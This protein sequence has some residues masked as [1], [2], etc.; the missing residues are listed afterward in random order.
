MKSVSCIFILFFC[1][2]VHCALLQDIRFSCA[3][4]VCTL[5][6]P[7]SSKESLPNYFQ[8]FD[9]SK[10][11]LRVAFSKTNISMENGTYIVDESSAWI[12][13][14]E[15]SVDKPKDLL[16]LD[17]KCGN[18]ITTDKN[19]VE[20]RNKTD[21]AINF[22]NPGDKK[23]NSWALSKIGATRAKGSDFKEKFSITPPGVSSVLVQKNS[24]WEELLIVLNFE[25]H[26]EATPVITDS[27]VE[28]SIEDGPSY[29]GVFQTAKSSFA[30]GL[31]W[32][33]GKLVVYLY[34]GK[35]PAVM[36]MKNRML[37]QNET[38]P[39]KLENWQAFA[40]SLKSSNYF[41]PSYEPLAQGAADFARRLEKKQ[42]T[43]SSLAQAIQVKRSD[44]SYIVVEEIASLF[45]NPSEGKPLEALVFGDR[46]KVLEKRPPFY[47]VRYQNK[48]GYVY[49]RDILQEAELTTSQREELRRRQKESPGGVDSIAAK[50]GWK[51]SDKIIYSS[52]GFR[53]PFI[54]VRG[55]GSDGINIDNLILAGVVY[56]NEMPMALFSDNK[57]RGQSYTLHEGDSVKNGK[58]IKISK[59]SVL[60]L[61]QE[62]GVSR[63]YTMSLPDKFGGNK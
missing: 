58:V 46:L 51:D 18:A 57:T 63:R 42:G 48:E 53:D 36:I 30:K 62:Y 27:T 59:T 24:E 60:F 23:S 15:I 19:L 9:P 11:V 35:K 32:T 45:P 56:E 25:L 43:E 17:F 12:R 29:S 20:L 61:L 4:N 40:T 39:G 3:S 52:Y 2:G 13:S 10:S 44:A 47:K 8:K 21:F 6:F 50:F 26:K 1:I 49:Q 5:E 33:N 55:L 7:F 28:L 37:L 31:A 16:L 54:E 34:Q 22:R 41:L 14:V 38:T